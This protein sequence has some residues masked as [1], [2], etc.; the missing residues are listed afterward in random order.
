MTNVLLQS[1]DMRGIRKVPRDRIC[2]M[3]KNEEDGFCDVKYTVIMIA[4]T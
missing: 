4:I 3:L 1:G 2:M